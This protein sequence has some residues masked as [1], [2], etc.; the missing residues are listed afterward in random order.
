M[1]NTPAPAA[2]LAPEPSPA[3]AAAAD[4]APAA[5]SNLLGG[6]QPQPQSGAP[7]EYADFT[8]PE[9][10]TLGADA[11][12]EVKALA[13]DLSLSQEQAQKVAEKWA[14]KLGGQ[15]QA[16]A[17]Y[18]DFALPEGLTVDKERM[19]D[20]KTLAK[21]LGL[22]QDAAQKLVD[23]QGTRMKDMLDAPYKLWTETQKQWQADITADPDIGGAKLQTNLSL[24]AKVIDAFGGDKLRQALDVTGAGNHPDVVRTFINMGKALAEGSFASGNPVKSSKSYGDVFYG[25]VDK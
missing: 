2:D 6:A 23:F 4:P 7:A 18:A 24:A 17:D 14:D 25:A 9:G 22:S 8:L 13:K 21:E 20:F 11:I 16:P 10:K 19:G 12:G 15:P 1:T 5:S 3:S